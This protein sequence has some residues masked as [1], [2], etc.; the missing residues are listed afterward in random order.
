MIEGINSSMIYLIYCKNICKC[1]NVSPTKK[2]KKK[3]FI[4]PTNKKK[5]KRRRT[6]GRISRPESLEE[7]PIKFGTEFWYLPN[8]GS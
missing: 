2:E 5:K 7:N 4:N 1:H 8:F 6:Y 3:D